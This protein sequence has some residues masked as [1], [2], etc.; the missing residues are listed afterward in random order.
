MTKYLIS[1]FKIN[2]VEEATLEF[3]LKKLKKQEIVF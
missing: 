3:R 1:S 2:M